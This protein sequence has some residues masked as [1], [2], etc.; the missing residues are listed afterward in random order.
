MA[1]RARARVFLHRGE[2][3]RF[4]GT[5]RLLEIAATRLHEASSGRNAP[6]ARNSR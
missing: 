5:E 4:P 6:A 2:E 3:L 1:S